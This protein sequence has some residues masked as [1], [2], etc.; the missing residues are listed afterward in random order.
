MVF[1]FWLKNACMTDVHMTSPHD[2]RD[3]DHGNDH[4]HDTTTRVGALVAHHPSGSRQGH[5]RC[6]SAVTT[7]AV[8][9]PTPTPQMAKSRCSD[10]SLRRHNTHK[11]GSGAGY[12]EQR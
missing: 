5:P 4:L 11:H 1:S 8:G 10:A 6:T 7:E 12:L 2:N 3:H 9:G